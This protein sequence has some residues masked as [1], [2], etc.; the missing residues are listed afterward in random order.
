MHAEVPT[1]T[2]SEYD[3]I[4]VGGGPAGSTAARRAA[5]MGLRVMLIDKSEFPRYKPCAG[6]IRNAVTSLLD[7]DVTGVLHRKISGFT[8]FSPSGQRIDCVP[9]DRS[10]PGY[11]VMRDEFDHL[12]LKKAREA[13]A[14][15]REGCKVTRVL[16]DATG[17]TVYTQDDMALRAD[18]LVGADGINGVVARSLGLYDGWHGD[19]AGVAIE[20]EARVG[21]KTVRDI[22]G[23]PT[24]YDA[25]VFFLYFGDVPHGYTWCFPKR[26]VLSLGAWCRQ[27]R[28]KGLRTAY[29]GW[30]Q[31]FCEEYGIEP[32]VLSE[33][34]ARF[35]VKVAD[36][37]VQGRTV[38]VGDAAGLVDAFTGEGIPHAVQSGI[39]AAEAVAEAVETSDPRRLTTYA[40]RC[41]RVIMKELAVAES[42][43]KLFY[44]SSKNM[45]TLSNFFYEDEYA[46]FLIAAAVGGL[47]SQKEVKRKMTLRMLR[48][49]PRAA[50]SLYL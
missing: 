13:G 12:L 21:E 44:R 31:R 33:S 3:V 17:V 5:L 23:D 24:G 25:D 20:V 45:E 39:I 43:A 41:K 30:Y 40:D 37:I 48:T 38:L 47:M 4:V 36:K 7:F 9:E 26:D 46:R 1:L 50:V 35:P 22:C 42:M 15:V 2:T 29:N 19:S 34:A 10:M 49:R 8:M 18:Y 6:A 27:D 28:A 16:D 14:E 11:T 32:Q